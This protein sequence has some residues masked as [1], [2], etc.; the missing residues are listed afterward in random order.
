MSS[1]KI[2]ARRAKFQ[3]Y[4]AMDFSDDKTRR[5]LIGIRC[6]LMGDVFLRKLIDNNGLMNY[7]ND[8]T[9]F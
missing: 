4:V 9:A 5:G 8:I 7:L 6:R 2:S 3:A 1:D